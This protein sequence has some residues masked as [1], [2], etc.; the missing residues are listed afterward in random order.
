MPRVADGKELLT[1]MI[2]EKDHAQRNI[3][4]WGQEIC[5][6]RQKLKLV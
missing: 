3:T 4:Q 2:L 5:K 6:E 1:Y